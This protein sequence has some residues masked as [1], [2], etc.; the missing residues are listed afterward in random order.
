MKKTLKVIAILLFAVTMVTVSSCSKER[1]YQNRIVGKWEC[2]HRATG[3]IDPTHIDPSQYHNE[4][5]AVGSIWDFTQDGLLKVSEI[6][7]TPSNSTE[8]LP[9]VIAGEYLSFGGIVT[10]YI[11]ELTNSS[12]IIWSC[13]EYEGD[14]YNYYEF[15][16]VR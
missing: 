12:L 3:Y 13:I 5:C 1:T 10:Y 7:N 6:A 16:K 8:A 4:D 2:I 15:Q 11:Q 9:Y 14:Y